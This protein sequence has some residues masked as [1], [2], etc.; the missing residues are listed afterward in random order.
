VSIL[1]WQ[2]GGSTLRGLVVDSLERT[3]P[4]TYRSTK[5]VPV[6]GTWKTV[7]RIHDGRT[8]TAAPIFM[9]EDAAIGAPEVAAEP[10]FT[11]DL[12]SEITLLQRERNFDH[13]TWLFAAA[14]LIVLVC[15]LLLVWA[16]SWGTVRI[17]EV[18][19]RNSL[20]N[21]RSTEVPIR[22]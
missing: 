14:S 22:T 9:A 18:T 13:P 12:V 11:R 17:S 1:A 3:G 21:T 8:L 4:G 5:P 6:D 10:A 16:L 19:P 7:L 20:R 2:G 15:T